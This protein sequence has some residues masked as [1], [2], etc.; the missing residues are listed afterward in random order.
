[1]EQVTPSRPFEF[2]GVDYFGPIFVRHGK[3]DSTYKV[4]VSLF[5]CLTTRAIH[6][7]IAEDMTAETFLNCLR[8]LVARRGKP[9]EFISDNAGQFI[10]TE[11]VLKIHWKSPA[12]HPG[13]QSYL[14]SEGITWKYIPEL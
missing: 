4:W 9:R 10:L 11:K 5:T 2:T 14:S 7:E 8:R 6:L 1:M 3:L 13:I 12:E